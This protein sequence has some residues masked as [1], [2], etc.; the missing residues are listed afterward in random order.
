[1]ILFALACGALFTGIIGTL[2]A[3]YV[4]ELDAT[5]RRRSSSG[6]AG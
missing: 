5:R 4:Y 3:V 6:R 2:G 1:V